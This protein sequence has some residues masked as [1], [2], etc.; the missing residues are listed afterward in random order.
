MGYKFNVWHS[1]P[2]LCFLLEHRRGRLCHILNGNKVGNY[3]AHQPMR[4]Y[5]PRRHGEHQEEKDTGV[6]PN[7][8]FPWTSLF[9]KRAFLEKVSSMIASQRT[10]C[11]NGDRTIV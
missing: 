6:L 7:S 11:F 9:G 2:R 8:E 10:G 3:S 1:R 5:S 4:K